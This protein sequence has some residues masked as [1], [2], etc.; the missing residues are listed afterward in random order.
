MGPITA[1][2]FL[3]GTF[4]GSWAV[5]AADVERG[6]GLSH[7]QFGLVLS[8]AMAGAAIANGVGGALA[9][10]LGTGRVLSASL[11]IWGGLL[12]IGAAVADAA[13]PWVLS[14]TL[15]LVIAIGGV[16]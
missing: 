9:E 10:R 6:L 11:A 2:F 13:V 16:V 12:L 1:A 15:V 3:F 4:W 14:A 7:A 8:A 5:S